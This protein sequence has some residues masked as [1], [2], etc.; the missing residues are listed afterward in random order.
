MKMKNQLLVL[1]GTVLIV[2]AMI[3]AGITGRTSVY[4]EARVIAATV[5][6]TQAMTYVPRVIRIN[7][8]D[9]VEWQNVSALGH[10]VT[11]DPGKATLSGDAVLPPGAM[12]F[13]S[14]NLQPGERF[15]YIFTVPGAYRY[16]CIPH[17]AAGMV[18]EIEVRP[19]SIGKSRG[20][21]LK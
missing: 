13:D 19:Q 8:G 7:V 12:P 15:R 21:D 2:A 6:M 14:G 1:G 18:G 5:R 17:E 11:A 4:K 20:I 10:T 3:A 9:T 16:F